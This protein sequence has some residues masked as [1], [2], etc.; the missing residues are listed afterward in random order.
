MNNIIDNVPSILT[1]AGLWLT[2]VYGPKVVAKVQG[3]NRKE[4]VAL[5]GDAQIETVYVQNIGLI[6]SEY[7][8]QV[9]GFKNELSEVRK[10]FAE[11]KVEHNK[12]VAEYQSQI[13]LLKIEIEQKEDKIDELQAMILTKNGIIATLK[14]ERSNGNNHE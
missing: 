2:Y 1:L 5:E 12:E 8:E 7:K 6:I 4:E 3:R 14:G 9:S 10:E 11:F 13:T